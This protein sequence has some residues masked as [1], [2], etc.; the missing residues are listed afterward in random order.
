MR[1]PNPLLDITHEDRDDMQLL[2]SEID[3]QPGRLK[4][5]L[6]E[7]VL[8]RKI[9]S[10]ARRYR[11]RFPPALHSV[12]DT[13]SKNTRHTELERIAADSRAELEGSYEPT[14]LERTSLSR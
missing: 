9:V 13:L 11:N 12:L 8:N 3:L 6:A 5:I 4:E 10:W 7:L 14:A 1:K 2:M